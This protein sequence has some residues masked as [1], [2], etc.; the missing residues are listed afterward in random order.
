M[1]LRSGSDRRASGPR[2][3]A[4]AARY[5]LAALLAVLGWPSPAPALEWGL[6]NPGETAMTAVR[7]RYGPPTRETTQKVDG[8]DST[9]WV[10]EDA[11]APT[12]MIRMVVE[13][14]LLTPQGYRPQLVRTLLLHPKPGTFNRGLIVQGWG[15]PTATGEQSGNPAY[16]YED[17]LFVVF[18]PDVQEVKTMLFTPKQK[19]PTPAPAPPR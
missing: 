10:Y 3:G 12:G 1:V 5:L 11:Q 7:A 19:I 2:A 6:V 4:I 16:L 13:F 17:G 15:P 8:Y 14:G 9:E 18:D